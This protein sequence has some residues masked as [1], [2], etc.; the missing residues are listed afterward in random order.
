M[1]VGMTAVGQMYVCMCVKMHI[2]AGIQS[3]GP[4]YYGA[5]RWIVVVVVAHSTSCSN[6][7]TCARHVLHPIMAMTQCWRIFFMGL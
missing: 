4:A 2:H 5:T 3:L 6:E 7:E 1:V